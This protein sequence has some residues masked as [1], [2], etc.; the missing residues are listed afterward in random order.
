MTMRATRAGCGPPRAPSRRPRGKDGNVPG[1]ANR[2][3]EDAPKTLTTIVTPTRVNNSAHRPTTSTRRS[4]R[5]R[6]AYRA[7]R[8]HDDKCPQPRGSISSCPW[9]TTVESELFALD[10]APFPELRRPATPCRPLRLRVCNFSGPQSSRRSQRDPASVSG[11]QTSRRRTSR[12]RGSRPRTGDDRCS[13]GVPR[14]REGTPSRCPLSYIDSSEGYPYPGAPAGCCLPRDTTRGRRFHV[15][16]RPVHGYHA[17]GGV[18]GASG[19]GGDSSG[20]GPPHVR[21]TV[22][23]QVGRPFGRRSLDP[24]RQLVRPRADE[25][26]TYPHLG[27]SLKIGT[28]LRP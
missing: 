5:R 15:W 3:G 17:E 1:A 11:T 22:V 2:D 7:R 26:S 14:G 18:L 13:R 9:S 19:V 8:H 28:R 16:Q 21:V 6:N 23:V 25:S 20:L 4:T 27:Q 10:T 12:P 24:L